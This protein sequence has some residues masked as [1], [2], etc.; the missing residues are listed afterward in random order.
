VIAASAKHRLEYLAVRLAAMELLQL[1][2]EPA[3]AAAEKV[4]A[5]ASRILKGRSRTGRENIAAAYPSKSPAEV[6]RLLRDVYANLF[7]TGAEILYLRRLVGPNTWRNYVEIENAG[8]ALDLYLEGRG[9]ILVGGHLGNW[10]ML[11][12][13]M[14]YIGLRSQVLARPLDNPLLDEFVLGVR[15]SGL[16]RIILKR[17]SGSQIER[18]L[19][20][21]GF[22]SILVDQDAG[23]RGA[24]VPFFG[25]P[26]STW[27][28]PAVLSMKTGAPILPGCCVRV[29]RG[30]RFKIIVGRPI[31]PNADAPVTEE[32]LRITADFTAQLEEWV[33]AYPEQ[34]LWLH[35]RWKSMPGPRS[36]VAA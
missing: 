1:P 26:A 14:P 9:G 10:E 35:R 27:R 34:Y 30:V 29:G 20:E 25:R 5:F 6:E 33:R 18:T 7:R 2:V 17:G 8:A 4:G 19:S 3:L 22:I 12:H 16:Q 13:V 11:G 24:F 28:T 31:Y 21:G 32:T 15:E 23:N 36:I